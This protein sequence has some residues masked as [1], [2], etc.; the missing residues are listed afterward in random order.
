MFVNVGD[1][2][3]IYLHMFNCSSAAIEIVCIDGMRGVGKRYAGLWEFSPPYDW[4]SGCVS[5][6]EGKST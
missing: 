3:S 2:C 5:L 1:I 4:K 6:R